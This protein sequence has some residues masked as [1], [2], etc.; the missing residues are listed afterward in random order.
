MIQMDQ[1]VLKVVSSVHNDKIRSNS[2]ERS[3]QCT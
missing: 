2:L 3:E 1:M